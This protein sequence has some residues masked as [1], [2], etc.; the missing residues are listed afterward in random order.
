MKI[1]MISPYFPPDKSVASI[2]MGSLYKY[3]V[4]KGHTVY[5]ITN[6]KNIDDM[7]HVS[8]VREKQSNSVL[9]KLSSFRENRLSYYNVLSEV[10]KK[11]DC[12]IILISG[13]PFYT[14]N[15]TEYIKKMGKL[16]VLDFRNPWVFDIRGLKDLL[17]FKRI[18]ARC[19]Q[20]PYE[21]NAIKY[22]TGVV[23][24]S[25]GWINKFKLFYPFQKNKFKLIENG[26]NDST[27]LNR[28]IGKTNIDFQIGIFGK[29]FYYSEKYSNI[30]LQALKENQQIKV[31]QIGNREENTDELL[32]KYDLSHDTIISTGFIDY[33]D[34]LKA[35][36]SSK[37]L[38]LIDNRKD[39]IGTKIYDY[40]FLNKPIIYIGPSKTYLAKMISS[41][42]NGFSCASKIEILEAIK[43]I[44][45][46][47]ITNLDNNINVYQYGRSC[48][49]QEYEKYL[50]RIIKNEKW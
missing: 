14:F 33:E 10:M 4:S 40:I 24:V 43:K 35:L 9:N 46:N 27:N 23:S 29:L 37:F 41:F 21:R 31:L 2:R 47:N 8:F 6:Y 5:V 1:I 25:P 15:L 7:E 3:L 19:I 13:G 30:F 36:M 34:G 48:R 50:E 44:M 16:S 38:L 42:Q 49:N 26:Y 39:A 11:F 20:L 17:S 45:N 22:S 28:N 18:I 32:D 12:D